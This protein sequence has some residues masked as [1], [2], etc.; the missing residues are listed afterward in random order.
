MVGL[1][2]T[3]AHTVRS[4]LSV[5]QRFASPVRA[6]RPDGQDA[7]EIESNDVRS[8]LVGSLVDTINWLLLWESQSNLRVTK[9]QKQRPSQDKSSLC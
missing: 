2:C 9:K 4:Q 6:D 1:H 5:Q 8:D 7:R 3:H